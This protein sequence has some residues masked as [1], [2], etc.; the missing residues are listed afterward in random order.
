MPILVSL[1]DLP[2]HKQ[3]DNAASIK[4]LY[5]YAFWVKM[6]SLLLVLILAPRD[7]IWHNI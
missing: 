3:Q 2:E 5:N 7:T 4:C 6:I 1:P